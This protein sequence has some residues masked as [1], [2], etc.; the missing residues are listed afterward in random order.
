VNIE[1]QVA[2]A[3][4]TDR[5]AYHEESTDYFPGVTDAAS[6]KSNPRMRERVYPVSG[7]ELRGEADTEAG[8]SC[9]KRQRLDDG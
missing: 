1:S 6:S 7:L 3:A 9:S 4:D 5:V 2:H 8:Q